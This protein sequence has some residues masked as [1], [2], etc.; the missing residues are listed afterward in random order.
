MKQ[1]HESAMAAL[2]SLLSNSIIRPCSGWGASNGVWF[3]ARCEQAANETAFAK[4]NLNRAKKRARSAGKLAELLIRCQMVVSE[5]IRRYAAPALAFQGIG[6]VSCGA[7]TLT[8]SH[9]PIPPLAI[10]LSTS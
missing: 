6:L 7:K 4:A 10:D 9:L 2:K 1:Q 3:M 8:P 5:Q